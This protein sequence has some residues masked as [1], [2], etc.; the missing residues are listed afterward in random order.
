MAASDGMAPLSY[1]TAHKDISGTGRFE[2]TMGSIPKVYHTTVYID[3][4]LVM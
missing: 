2:E 3:S 4:F 1:T